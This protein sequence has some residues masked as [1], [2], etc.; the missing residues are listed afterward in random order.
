MDK[1]IKKIDVSIIIVHY[2]VKKE[3]LECIQS[4]IKNTKGITYEIIVVDNDEEKSLQHDL[5]KN[6]PDVLYIANDDKGFGEGNNVGFSYAT[7]KYIFFLN[8]DTTIFNGTV[9]ALVN[10]LKKNKH[11]GVVAPILYHQNL[12]PFEL[13]GLGRLTPLRGIV[14]LSF[15]NKLFP[16]N[17]ISKA[18]WQPGW[19]KTKV[20]EV[21]VVPGTAFMMRKDFYEKL[22]GFDENFFLYFEEFDLCKRIQSK[23]YHLYMI[24]EAKVMHLWGKSTEQMSNINSIFQ[25]SR[26]FYFKKHYGLL[27]AILVEIFA[28]AK[29]EYFFLFLTLLLSGGIMLYK[30]SSL[31]VFIGDQAWFY[32]A[33]RDLLLGKGIPLVGIP[34]SHSWLHQ[35]PFWTYLLAIVLWLGNFNPVVGGYLSVVVALATTF[36][37]Y[38]LGRKIFS[39]RIGLV[40]SLLFATSPLVI[41]YARMPYHTAP[42]PL[43]T[44]L[45]FFSLY[46]W[47]RGKQIYFSLV[48][49][50]LAILYNFE[51][52]TVILAFHFLL[53]LAYGLWK[54]KEWVMGLTQK[55]IGFAVL[56][57]ILPML[58][59]FIYD[60]T[61]GYKQTIVYAGWLVFNAVRT[62]ARLIGLQEK[63]EQSFDIFSFV[64]MLLTRLVFLPN[65]AIA[66]LLLGISTIVT[67]SLLLKQYKKKQIDSSLILLLLWFL[68]GVGIYVGNRVPSEA[69]TPILY[70]AIFFMLAIAFDRFMRFRSLLTTLILGSIMLLNVLFL[71]KHNYFMSDPGGITYSQRSDAVLEILQK[72]DGKPYQLIGRGSGSQFESFLMP[73]EY[74]GW[75]YG[76]PPDGKL[77][78]F[79]FIIEERK[80]TLIVKEKQQ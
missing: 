39:D 50:F 30:L 34:S 54:R 26:F 55:I 37:M 57:A 65:G 64:H 49:F 44:L 38:F 48:L 43:F 35:G 2:H 75:F 33:A 31:M 59:V 53:V 61:H 27:S 78:S 40:A 1:N 29:K 45:Y 51:L 76:N 67:V 58:P 73:Y 60:R 17:P 11:A 3:I 47:I 46:Q 10:F 5:S 15:I 66:L 69:Y 19:D 72:V 12:Q 4:I 16:Q 68:L 25:K 56:L 77:A 6:F 20:K 7:G 52:A 32:L 8:P 28:R 21:D 14:A 36:V 74:L 41:F 42:I 24:P 22:G 63:P 71:L 79:Q 70:P 9:T 18:Y 13:Q 80:D 62:V 23:G